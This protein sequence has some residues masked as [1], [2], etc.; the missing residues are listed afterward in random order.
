MKRMLDTVTV[1]CGHCGNLSFLTTSPPLQGHVSLTL[2]VHKT[3]F[4][5]AY[6]YALKV[7]FMSLIFW[8]SRCRALVGVSIR[9]EALLPPPLRLPVTS[10]RLLDHPLSLNVSHK[11]LTLPF[12]ADLCNF[13]RFQYMIDYKNLCIYMFG[14]AAP[15]KK[16]RL[17]SA[18]NRF[19]RLLFNLF[20]FISKFFFF[21]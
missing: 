6:T 18:Y 15:E 21:K 7:V 8:T 3:W 11:I 12:S 17:P 2:Q 19:M 4:I 14:F 16:Q 13:S 10:H 5:H 20:F 9:R 1:K